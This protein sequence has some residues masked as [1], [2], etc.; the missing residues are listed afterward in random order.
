M[1]VECL[2]VETLSES[3]FCL[4]FYTANDFAACIVALIS[5]PW[6]G[7]GPMTVLLLCQESRMKEFG[8]GKTNRPDGYLLPARCHREARIRSEVRQGEE[9]GPA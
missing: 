4:C 5:L 3:F 9:N 2:D 8:G 7:L 6:P 1:N